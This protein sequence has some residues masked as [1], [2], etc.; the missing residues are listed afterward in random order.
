[1]IRYTVFEPATLR[2]VAKNQSLKAAKKMIIENGT[3]RAI[4]DR[5]VDYALRVFATYL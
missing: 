1:M 4:D 5:S 3:Y 2:I